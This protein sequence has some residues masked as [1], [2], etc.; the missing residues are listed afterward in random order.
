MRGG[1]VAALPA[2]VPLQAYICGSTLV[3][4]GPA[5]LAAPPAAPA[6]GWPLTMNGKKL[7]DGL[8]PGGAPIT[9][10]D[11][12]YTLY[13]ANGKLYAVHSTKLPVAGGQHK[14]V[15]VV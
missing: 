14:Q 13:Q 2:N 8:V 10:G 1:E 11:N 5:N 4:G 15:H 12:N 6:A 3:D 7:D 9:V